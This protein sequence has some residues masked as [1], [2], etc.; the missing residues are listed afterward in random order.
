ML[1]TR[2][3]QPKVPP[4]LRSIEDIRGSTDLDKVLDLAALYELGID[5]SHDEHLARQGC[6]HPSSCGYCRRAQ[7][8]QFIRTPP[9]NRQ[10]KRLK[11]IFEVGHHIHDIIQARFG[12]LGPIL[13]ARG[14]NYEFHKEVTYDPE[15]DQL[16]LELDIGGT[17]DGIVRLWNR[18][19]EQRILLEA[20]SQ[21]DDRHEKLLA[22]PTAWPNHLKQSHIYAYR[23]DLPLI[24][25]F[26]VNKNNQKRETRLQLFENKIFDEAILYFV[27]CGDFVARGEL[28]PR[29]ESWF[30]CKE[31]VYR[32]MCNPAVL[33]RKNTGLATIP[34]QIRR[35]S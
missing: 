18:D 7:V 28:P 12:K 25:V 4:T 22:M 24:C 20:K 30:E 35:R 19:F 26:Y 1:S 29:E 34:A 9:T 11:E 14:L 17:A 5:N 16:Y 23:F 31:C 33:R 2:P 3:P 8:L 21:G 10:S 6:W 13:R 15:T 27:E 32:K